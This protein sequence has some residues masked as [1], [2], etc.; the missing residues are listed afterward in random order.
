MSKTILAVDDSSTIRRALELTFRA[1][2]FRVVTAPGEP[3]A[4]DQFESV[5]PD[6]LLV[7]AGL[8]GGAGYRLA[9]A[10]KS[11]DPSIPVVLLTSQ[12][13]PYDASMGRRAG[14]GSHVDKP[15]DTQALLDLVQR[16]VIERERA[17]AAVPRAEP[18]PEL[19][20]E[21]GGPAQ[22]PDDPH[23]DSAD[24]E[25]IEEIDIED[26]PD[27]PFESLEPTPAPEPAAARPRTSTQP[28][29]G[30]GAAA[31]P[32]DP[33]AGF[34]PAPPGAA[35]PE[36]A[37]RSGARMED[38]VVTRASE[39]EPILRALPADELRRI[40]RDVVERVAW[41]VVPDL[42]ETIIREELDRLTSE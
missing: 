33:G 35:A 22:I 28:D 1:T 26:V 24:F 13:H 37:P 20:I 3:E 12:T 15:F 31:P 2:E 9:G 25:E 36:D 7:D 19:E 23:V 4:L 39:A 29:L 16:E 11:R 30:H 32:P 38:A 41:E 14:V 18:E 17:P 10:F 42:A 34:A 27:E 6:L 21:V 40:A 8:E 5:R